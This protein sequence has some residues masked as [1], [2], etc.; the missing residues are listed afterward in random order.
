[1]S[2]RISLE[3]FIKP[4]DLGLPAPPRSTDNLTEPFSVLSQLQEGIELIKYWEGLELTAY[5]DPATNG[6]PY[7]IGYGCTR[8][9]DGTPI[10]PGE[11]ITQQQAEQML[12]QQLEQDFLPD[13]QTVP[14]WS[15]MAPHHLK[16]HLIKRVLS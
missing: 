3:D 4:S 10:Q 11:S 6:K 13:L 2:G 15:E 5:P 1:M 8:H 12:M 7:T 16:W 14:Y 9:N